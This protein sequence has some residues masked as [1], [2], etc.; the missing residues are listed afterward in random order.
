VTYKRCRGCREFYDKALDACPFCGT[1]AYAFNKSL[2]T[3]QLNN[4]LYAQAERAA[5]SR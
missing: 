4:A 3:G 2:R 5:A 1:E